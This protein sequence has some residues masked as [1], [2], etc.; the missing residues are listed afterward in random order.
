MHFRVL[1]LGIATNGTRRSY[2][3]KLPGQKIFLGFVILAVVL[4]VGYGIYLVGSPGGQRLLRFDDARVSDLQNISQTID[5]YWGLN[6][7]LPAALEDLQGSRLYF[8]RSIRDPAT[9]QPYEYRVIDGNQYQLCAVFDTDS[10]QKEQRVPRPRAANVWDHGL[11]RTC[12]D[13]EGQ[14]P[15]TGPLDDRPVRVP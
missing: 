8:V 15:R 6:E 10:S 4:A 9:Q 1:P 7:E 5:I 11:G 13:L 12:F 3:S 14:A 2:V